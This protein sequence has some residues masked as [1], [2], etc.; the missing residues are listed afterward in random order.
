MEKVG[1]NAYRLSIPPY[2][3]IDLVVNVKKLKLYE[4]SLLYQEEEQVLP[5][6][7]DIAPYAQEF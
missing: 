7:K 6:I 4:P 1:D 5:T 2:I 3:Y